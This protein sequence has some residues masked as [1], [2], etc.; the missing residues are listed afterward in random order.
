MKRLAK[1]VGAQDRIDF[2][3][4][5]DDE[6]ALNLFANALAVYYAPVDEDYGFATVEAM[7]SSKLVV[8]TRGSGGVLEFVEDGA[9]GL[10]AE[11]GDV[12]QLSE[13]IDQLYLDR[14]TAARLGAAARDR[15]S[16]ITWPATIQTLLK[17]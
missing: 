12:Q 16:R 13:C 10:V 17:D 4:F 5:V 3:G 14:A 15:V 11:E 1:Q 7:K 9:T 6:A 8:T 2:L